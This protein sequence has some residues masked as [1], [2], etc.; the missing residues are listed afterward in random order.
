M[1]VARTFDI[2]NYNYLMGNLLM[3]KLL[4]KSITE[5]YKELKNIASKLPPTAGSIS[6]KKK[7]LNHRL[8]AKKVAC[9][10]SCMLMIKLMAFMKFIY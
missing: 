4:L 7:S 5:Q 6:F 3:L 9:K 1:D 2:L 10:K 8:F